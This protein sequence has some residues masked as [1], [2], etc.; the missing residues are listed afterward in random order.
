[1]YT[2]LQD[3]LGARAAAIQLQSATEYRAYRAN[4]AKRLARTRKSLKIQTRPGHGKKPKQLQTDQIVSPEHVKSLVYASERAWAAAMET[5]AVLETNRG[6]AGAMRRHVISKLRRATT[7][8]S[9]LLSA[10]NS[11]ALSDTMDPRARLEVYGYGGLINGALRFEQK[12]WNEAIDAYSIARVCLTMTPSELAKDAISSVVD[13]A[14]TYSL[15][16]A[17]KTRSVDVPTLS[18]QRVGS[19]NDPV[20]EL[21]K[22]I[23]PRALD[24]SSTSQNPTA[25]LGDVVWRGHRAQAR[26]PDLASSILATLSKDKELSEA[27]SA[28]MSLFDTVLQGWQDSLDI[29]R[30]SIEHLESSD[31]QSHDAESQEL[32]VIGTYINYNLLLRRI[33]RDLLLIGQ[34]EARTKSRSTVSK[35]LE[36]ARD[37]VRIYDTVLQSTGELKNLPGLANDEELSSTLETTDAYFN[38]RRTLTVASAYA[39]SGKQVE[40]LALYSL[41]GQRLSQ[42][43]QKVSV[44][45]TGDV[46][47]QTKVNELDAEVQRA[48]SRARGLAHLS[49]T[50][51]AQ[52][53][54]AKEPVLNSLTSYPEG[55]AEEVLSNLVDTRSVEDRVKPAPAKPVFFDIAFNYI[56]YDQADKSSVLSADTKTETESPKQSEKKGGLLGSLWGR[57]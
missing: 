33:Q 52:K 44:E 43:P 7:H 22:S 50:Q 3:V 24:V 38:A 53:G 40:A 12:R 23:D 39:L 45:L 9:V 41:A 20:V 17:H 32:Y 28:S 26:D 14:L 15:Y 49:Q 10:V 1:M 57:K 16:Q 29:A 5:K 34:L 54:T 2:P 4:A 18:V 30:G 51:Q 36:L 46:I 31:Q 48:I 8:I 47:S 56:D 42:C 27:K 19:L 37:V 6:T 55:S 25:Q 35:R 11:S 13:P 21:I